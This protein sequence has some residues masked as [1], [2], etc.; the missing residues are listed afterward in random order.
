MYAQTTYPSR[1]DCLLS[2]DFET[3]SFWSSGR[4][5]SGSAFSGD[6]IVK[7]SST[8]TPVYSKAL[9]LEKNVT[10]NFQFW[11]RNPT[12]ASSDKVGVY[13]KSKYASK[14]NVIK[15]VTLNQT[16]VWTFCSFEFSH[17]SYSDFYFGVTGTDV[18]IDSVSVPILYK[19]AGNLI[20][21]GSFE[22]GN[23]NWKEIN[24]KPILFSGNA[25]DGMA[26]GIVSAGGGV[27]CDFETAP[28]TEYTLSFKYK[29]ELS[30]AE[31]G[32]S[33]VRNGFNEADLITDKKPLSATSDWQEVSFEF[34]SGRCSAERL[35]LWASEQGE[36]LVDCVKVTPSIQKNLIQNAGFE[37]GTDNWCVS[38]GSIITSDIAN[39]GEKSLKQPS[40]LYKKVWQAFD[41]EENTEYMLSFCYKGT[42]WLKWSVCDAVSD[43]SSEY[44]PNTDGGAGYIIGSSV[45]PADKVNWDNVNVIFNSG[46]YSRIAFVMQTAS[47]TSDLLFDDISVTKV[48]PISEN[49]GYFV[50]YANKTPYNDYPYITDD[51]N[52]LF[53]D[54]SFEGSTDSAWNTPSFINSWGEIVRDSENG[55]VYKFTATDTEVI[56]SVTMNVKPNTDYWLTLKIKTPD[57]SDENT[58]KLY[59][60]IANVDTN[61]FLLGKE[62]DLEEYRVFSATEQL[63]VVAADDEWHLVSAKFRTADETKIMFVI[64]G[65]KAVSYF[66]D[67]YF[68]EDANKVKY[69]SKTERIADISVTDKNPSLR[70]I[71]STGTNLFENPE[72]LEGDSFWNTECDGN[73][74]FETNL[75]VVVDK[76]T[77]RGNSLKYSN[78][79]KYPSRIYY[80]KW[81]DV[82]PY[83]EYTF[84]AKCKIINFVDDKTVAATPL[85]AKKTV[86]K[87]AYTLRGGYFGLL[88]GYRFESEISENQMLP[89]PIIEYKFSSENY[90]DSNWEEIAISFNSGDRNRVGFMIFDGGGEA[91]IDD[92]RL[93]RTEDAALKGTA[94]KP[95]RLPET[96]Y[97]SFDRIAFE[98]IAGML[99]GKSEDNK[100]FIWSENPVFT[101]LKPDTKYYFSVKYAETD[102]KYEG[103]MSDEIALNTYKK[104]DVNIDDS[105][106]VIDLVRLKKNSVSLK[107]NDYI[108][109]LNNS[110]AIGADD[111]V[112]LRRILMG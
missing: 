44:Y 110:G 17:S 74:M 39:N 95:S 26:C 28:Y 57:L 92:L 25:N 66:D 14:Y 4:I 109:D 35:V 40:G 11:Y 103:D 29:G 10:Y 22:Q 97:V 7:G 23:I 106:N 101:D 107:E 96:E 73:V 104:G 82:Q 32:L 18:E 50:T 48:T 111:L 16:D 20:N 59:Y 87:N 52:N 47:E 105:V 1:N 51:A 49:D 15:T 94:P 98:K 9:P 67:I 81:V 21:N 43:N 55:A 68:F 93:F 2:D 62:P 65:T 6:Y 80:T 58:A 84:A 54:C 13:Y 88:S 42:S 102:E 60:G 24:D 70:Y 30:G 8:S 64:R 83:T 112:I 100:E 85:D 99:Y 37:N 63:N 77:K 19:T 79:F 31:F 78:L 89:T 46:E 72:F 38:S 108:S 45:S 90:N 41:V 12:A 33:R 71:K 53:G 69:L 3:N 91:L 76:T 61:E 5:T 75:S 36:L 27:Y 56:N 34:N 86:Y